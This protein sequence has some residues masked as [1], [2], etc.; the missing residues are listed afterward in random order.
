MRHVVARSSWR[1]GRPP[2][3]CRR[4]RRG[5]RR[6]SGR[7]PDGQGEETS[8]A[9]NRAGNCPQ[10]RPRRRSWDRPTGPRVWSPRRPY[11]NPEASEHSI[12]RGR[13]TPSRG[14]GTT[15]SPYRTDRPVHPPPGGAP[16]Q[17]RSPF[18]MTAVAACA[19]PARPAWAAI[20]PSAI[21]PGASRGSTYPSFGMWTNN[22]TNRNGATSDSPTRHSRRV[23]ASRRA[24]RRHSNAG[25][26]PNVSSKSRSVS[27][28]FLPRAS[29][30]PFHAAVAQCSYCLGARGRASRSPDPPRG[31]PTRPRGRATRGG[32]RRRPG[33]SAPAA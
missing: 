4:S 1:P 28:A 10:S 32:P 13:A 16:S 20:T 26:S 3:C 22:A 11:L 23:A 5:S 19:L 9:A 25:A 18:A 2:S 8:R 21:M 7:P 17:N 24:R 30:S 29:A 33:A 12:R 6:R 27:R 14:A 31:A 15:T